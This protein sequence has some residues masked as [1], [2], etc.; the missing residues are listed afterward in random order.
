M[1]CCY[2]KFILTIGVQTITI[3]VRVFFFFSF[4]SKTCPA[5]LIY[6]IYKLFL[7]V[8]DAGWIV[9]VGKFNGKINKQYCT[10]TILGRYFQDAK[11]SLSE[12]VSE[13]IVAC[14]CW[15]KDSPMMS[16]P[17]TSKFWKLRLPPAMK[18]VVYRSNGGASRSYSKCRCSSSSAL[19]VTQGSS[20]M[21]V[22]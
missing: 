3:L 8:S 22:R 20:P 1:S 13:L 15:E 18:L 6:Q 21:L 12:F 19:L 11:W 4:F 16:F 7:V 2:I 10:Y 17:W 5:A 14:T 9:M